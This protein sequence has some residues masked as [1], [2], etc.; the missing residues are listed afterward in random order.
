MSERVPRGRS[1]HCLRGGSRQET[2][3]AEGATVSL[4]QA[5]AQD[6]VEA[7]EVRVVM[8]NVETRDAGRIQVQRCTEQTAKHRNVFRASPATSHSQ[9][10]VAIDQQTVVQRVFSGTHEAGCCPRILHKFDSKQLCSGEADDLP[11]HRIYFQERLSRSSH[12]ILGLLA[13]E[14]D[15]Y[16]AFH[17]LHAASG[18]SDS[19][20]RAVEALMV[21]LICA[22]KF[23]I[24]S[25]IRLQGRICTNHGDGGVVRKNPMLTF[26]ANHT[27]RTPGLQP[28]CSRRV[29]LAALGSAVLAV[30]MGKSE[31]SGRCLWPTPGTA[32]GC[33]MRTSLIENLNSYFCHQGNS[34]PSTSPTPASTMVAIVN[35]L[36][37]AAAAGLTESSGYNTANNYSGTFVPQFPSGQTQLVAP[38]Q[39]PKFIG[40]AFGVQNYTCSSGNNFTWE[41]GSCRRAHRCLVHRVYVWLLHDPER[42][43]RLLDERHPVLYPEHHRPPP[44]PEPARDPRPALLRAQPPPLAKGLSPK[45]DFTS[46]GRFKGVPAEIIRKAEAKQFPWYRYFDLSPPE[47][48]ELI[49]IQNAGRLVHRLVHSFPKLQ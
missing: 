10:P 11:G 2:A 8:V 34:T 39:P 14:H 41:H 42:L 45:W 44:P 5:S 35:A 1:E 43:V 30:S 17:R 28:L 49:G 9:A 23:A 31:V 6:S 13:A 26:S 4:G 7:S 22:Q 29:S 19:I 36:F 20:H 48:G 38:S 25:L 16:G 40:L 21:Q 18:L 37:A 46:S 32:T 12:W 27:N 47:I 3:Q 24:N 33:T 15:P